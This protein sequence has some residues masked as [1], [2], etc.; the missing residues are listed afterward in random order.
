[1]CGFLGPHDLYV[2]DDINRSIRSPAVNVSSS[3]SLAS[4][5]LASVSTHTRHFMTLSAHVSTW[6]AFS[7][8][9]P[10]AQGH[11][12]RPVARLL[13]PFWPPALIEGTP[14]GPGR[15]SHTRRAR[16]RTPSFPGL[17]PGTSGPDPASRPPEPPVRPA[18]PHP[19]T[20]S[21]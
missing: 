18:E 15:W 6:M 19:G 16:D 2:G 13:R 17:P 10:G 8:F 1:M 7:S 20:S 21:C 14:L 12:P 9:C 4:G 11:P 3:G 5:D